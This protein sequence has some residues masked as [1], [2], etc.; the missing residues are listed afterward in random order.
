MR[1]DP[2]RLQAQALLTEIDAG[3][4]NSLVVSSRGGGTRVVGADLGRHWNFRSVAKS[5]G[6]TKRSINIGKRVIST[7]GTMP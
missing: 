6:S 4:K 7:A 2:M 1:W 5:L 3:D